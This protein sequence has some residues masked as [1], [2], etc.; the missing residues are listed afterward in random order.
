MKTMNF[1]ARRRGT[2]AIAIVAWS[3]LAAVAVADDSALPPDAAAQGPAA[4]SRGTSLQPIAHDP[5]RRN[6]GAVPIQQVSHPRSYAR[7]YRP[8]A[9]YYRPYSWY[10]R[11][12]YAY[13]RWSLTP[14]FPPYRYYYGFYRP[15][16]FGPW[17][18]FRSPY[19][20]PHFYGPGFYVYTGPVAPPGSYV[21]C[22]YW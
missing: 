9:Y 17:Y 3:L 14:Y 2:S 12:P 5:A 13:Y 16:Y 1:G 6:F 4:L 21:G 22:Y 20:V 7:Y 18:G 19:F 11:S 15:P 10:Y 8:Y